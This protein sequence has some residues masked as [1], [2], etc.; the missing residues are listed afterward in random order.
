MV[1]QLTI[2]DE[3]FEMYLLSPGSKKRCGPVMYTHHGH[4]WSF[5]AA[6]FTGSASGFS[7]PIVWR[8]DS[9]KF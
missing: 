2:R 6:F 5:S 4:N 8:S 3:S 1:Q 9:S 7:S